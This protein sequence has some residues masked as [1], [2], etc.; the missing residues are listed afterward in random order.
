MNSA[1]LAFSLSPHSLSFKSHPKAALP[2]PPSPATERH[3]VRRRQ[4]AKTITTMM[5]R[6]HRFV[7]RADDEELNCGEGGGS[8]EF[9]GLRVASIFII[10]IGSMFGALFP[11]LARRTKWLSS[12]V[13]HGLF[14]FAK[15]FGSGVIVRPHYFSFLFRFIQPFIFFFG[16]R[17]LDCYRIHSLAGSCS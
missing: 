7:R 2:P 16:T 3:P 8:D 11:V 1:R 12:R 10:L 15:Y 4:K 13:P 17:S 5:A 6:S 14:D 9:F